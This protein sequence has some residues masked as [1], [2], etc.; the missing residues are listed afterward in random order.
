[1]AHPKKRRFLNKSILNQVD[2]L[3]K[4]LSYNKVILEESAGHFHFHFSLGY[5]QQRLFWVTAPTGNLLLLTR[6]LKVRVLGLVL[7]YFSIF[8]GRF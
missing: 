1:L 6:V 2:F 5:A 7:F 8:W 3:Q 4:Q